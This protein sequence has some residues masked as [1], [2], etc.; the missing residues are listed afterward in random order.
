M[1]YFT[2]KYLIIFFICWIVGCSDTSVEPPQ[3]DEFNIIVYNANVGRIKSVALNEKM[4]VYSWSG[5]SHDVKVGGKAPFLGHIGSVNAVDFNNDGTLLLSGSS[6]HNIKLWD[7]ETGELLKTFSEHITET[8]DVIFTMDGKS[9]VSTENDYIVY[10]HNAVEGPIGRKPFYGHTRTVNSVDI[11]NDMSTIISGSSDG[12]IK[13]WDVES[14]QL[15]HSINHSLRV[16]TIGVNEV[17]FNKNGSIIVSCGND[18]SINFWDATSFL[19]VKNI[20]TDYMVNAVSFHYSG[21]YLAACGKDTLV[22][23]YNV[24]DFSLIKT[25]EGHTSSIID[26]N[27]SDINNTLISGGNDEKVIVWYNV[28]SE[29]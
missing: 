18:S 10:W 22:Y 13:I 23:I 9:A 6:D 26:V 24:S 17:K 4:K 14:G 19:L 15:I 16:N 25:L 3:N 29:D 12:T 11:N 1:N 27:F 7:V 8:T 20:K 5:Q 28:F 21:Y 2:S